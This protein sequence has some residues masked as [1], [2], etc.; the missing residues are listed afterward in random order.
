MDVKTTAAKALAGFITAGLATLVT[1]WPPVA[2][3][4]PPDFANTLAAL[5]VGG[6]TSVFVYYIP[7]KPKPTL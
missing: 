5:I 3:F 7:N 2:A 1:R 6:V 4:I